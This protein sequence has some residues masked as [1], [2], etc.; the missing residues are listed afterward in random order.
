MG[1]IVLRYNS[2]TGN[3]APLVGLYG[4][5]TVPTQIYLGHAGGGHHYSNNTLSVTANLNAA[6]GS[7]TSIV[8]TSVL[9]DN[10]PYHYNPLKQGTTTY[11]ISN[12][13]SVGT[14]PVAAPTI[15]VSSF[16]SV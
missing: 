1:T 15:T 2:N 6:P 8:L 14:V 9:T 13:C 4:L 3:T 10:D 7:A 11:T 16:V 5:T 12:L